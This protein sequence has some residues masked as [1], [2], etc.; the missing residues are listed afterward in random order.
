MKRTIPIRK[1]PSDNRQEQYFEE[2]YKAYFERLFGYALVVTKSESLA[3]DVVSEVFFNLWNART[4]LTSIRELKSYLFTSVKNQAVR[5]LS[6]DPAAFHSQNY[7]Q[8]TSSIDKVN[9]EE[10]MMGKEL[11]EFISQVIDQLP[12]QCALVFRMVKEDNRKYTEVAEELGISTDTVKYHMKTALK[13]IR[14]ELE[15]HFPDT[16]VI[17]WISTGSTALIVSKLLLSYIQ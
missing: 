7:E 1:D 12:P 6:K 5:A 13:K 10:L 17:N 14:Q 9:P 8:V 15:D 2:V 11:D 16:T 4:D 3:K